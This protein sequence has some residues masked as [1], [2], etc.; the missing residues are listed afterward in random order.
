M[1]T[2]ADITVF[3]LVKDEKTRMEKWKR[4]NYKDVWWFEKDSVTEING[5]KNNNSLDVRIPYRLDLDIENFSKGDLILKG[6]V[7]KDIQ[8]SSEL[9]EYNV[10]TIT[11]LMNNNF[12]SN[13]H[14]HI[15]GN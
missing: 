14:I 9:S 3:H 2:N 15:K 5:F 11:S 7:D 13:K 4:F 12:G 8:S 6:L 10:Y 1:I